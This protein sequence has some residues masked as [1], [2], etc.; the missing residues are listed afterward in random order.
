MLPKGHINAA[1][2]AATQLRIDRSL[3]AWTFHGRASPRLTLVEDTSD[4]P[5]LSDTEGQRRR[6][7]RRNILW[8]APSIICS[9]QLRPGLTT[10]CAAADAVSFRAA[11]VR[12][13]PARAEQLVVAPAAPVRPEQGW[14]SSSTP[15]A[16]HNSTPPDALSAPVA[17]EAPESVPAELLPHGSG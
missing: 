8:L 15:P 12:I 2:A 7:H 11:C 9:G 6:S 13:H 4:S 17:A 1:P 5:F 3:A 14:W 10:H 16:P